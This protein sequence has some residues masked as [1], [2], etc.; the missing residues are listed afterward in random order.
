M[1]DKSSAGAEFPASAEPPR[2]RG[3][4]L[5]RKANSLGAS[6]FFS[7]SAPSKRMSTREKTSMMSLFSNSPVHNGPLT[8]AARHVPSAFSSSAEATAPVKLEDKERAGLAAIATAAEVEERKRFEELEKKIEAEFESVRSREANAHVV[9]NHC[10]WFSWTKIHLLEEHSLP[11]FFNGKSPNRTPATYMEIRNW[12]VKKFHANPNE[13]IELKDLSYLEVADLEARQEVLEFLDYWGLINFHPFPQKDSSENSK[14]DG[15]TEDLLLEKLFRFGPVSSCTEL[16]P[17]PSVITSSFPPGFFPDSAAI[18]E[19]LLQPEGPA[20]EYHCNSC[21]ADCSRK[22]YHCPKQ[23]DYDLCADC[24]SNGKFDTD[25]SSSDFILMEPGEVRGLSGGKWTD[26]ETLLLL[27]AI[28][29]YKENWSEIAEHVATKTKAQCILHFVQMPIEDSFYE[30]NDMED[31]LKE[32]ADKAAANENAPE[33]SDAKAGPK[34]DQSQTSAMEISNPEETGEKR[35]I[36]ENGG[37]GKQGDHESESKTNEVKATS[38][39]SKLDTGEGKAR[40]DSEGKAHEESGEGKAREESGEGKAREESGEGRVCEESGEGKACEESGEDVALK[41]LTEALEANGYVSSPGLS[42]AEVGNPVMALATFFV[43]LVG[44]D[45]ASASAHNS[46]KSLSSSSPGVQLAARHCFL[47]EHPP[48][49][50]KEQED[51][52]RACRAVAENTEENPPRDSHDE[53]NQIANNPSSGSDTLPSAD[54]PDKDGSKSSTEENK[55]KGS[56][57]DENKEKVKTTE[58]LDLGASHGGGET[59]V[60]KELSDSDRS[61]N[62]AGKLSKPESKPEPS[63]EPVKEQEKASSAV[64]CS[65]HKEMGGDV[66]MVSDTITSEKNDPSASTAGKEP[67]QAAEVSKDAD[68]VSD[69]LP[70]DKNETREQPKL[71]LAS[72]SVETAVMLKDI[73]I[74]SSEAKDTDKPGSTSALV[75]NGATTDEDQKDSTTEKPDDEGT[76]DSSKIDKLK[77]AGAAALSAAAVKA[78]LLANQE[79]DQIR[80]L[81]AVMIE[82]QLHKLEMKLAFFNDMDTLILRVKEQLDR[83]RQRL[84]QDRAQIIAARLGFA[85][86]SS[87]PVQPALAANRIAMNFSNAF[88]RPP[89]SL[90]S[91]MPPIPRPLGANTSDPLNPAMAGNSTRPSSQDTA[92]SVETK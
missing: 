79:E 61:L 39:P 33:T 92:S 2:R 50:G 5:K 58:E 6:S 78:K 56:S 70:V 82:K 14:G 68:I 37:E 42:F 44:G 74:T 62:A 28:E 34:E 69:A 54:N 72:D 71:S 66:E 40:E 31:N 24:F 1:D 89:I 85:A 35:D 16:V 73:D 8:R 49:N 80:Q 87:K 27:E 57:N 65:E 86:S 64:E 22:R 26:Q 76:K 17:K 36:S 52:D 3:G 32:S 43:R 60:S 81:A 18:R 75:E 4:G 63:P 10:G 41:A 7:S 77:R 48:D 9:P 59:N 20:V 29:I 21:S 45:V 67:A 19:E 11:S 55:S 15:A 53:T 23:A 84:Y 46:L 12:I 83:S 47:L 91:Q 88:P 30:C 13:Q 90:T 51:S 25:M 38:E